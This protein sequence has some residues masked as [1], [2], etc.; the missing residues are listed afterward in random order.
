MN[1]GKNKNLLLISLSVIIIIG[2]FLY[3]SRRVVTPF[4]IAFALAY[5]L[6]PLVDKM[7]SRGVS[8]TISVLFLMVAFFM[9]A[10]LACI[11]LVPIL[12]M[13][14]EIL[15]QNIPVYIEILQGW[16]GPLLDMVRGLSLIHI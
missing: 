10:V 1:E 13:Q 4:F 3:F 11:F 12:S 2:F 7:V 6:D 16:L 8:R 15:V 5:L 14:T 9:M